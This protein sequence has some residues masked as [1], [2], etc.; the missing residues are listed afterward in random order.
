[1]LRLQFWMDP[2]ALSR[3]SLAKAAQARGSG[4]RRWGVIRGSIF[5]RHGQDLCESW[6]WL[7]RNLTKVMAL[8][9]LV[10]DRR[11]RARKGHCKSLA[12]CRACHSMQNRQEPLS[13]IQCPALAPCSGVCTMNADHQTIKLPLRVKPKLATNFAGLWLL[14]SFA[15]ASLRM[16]SLQSTSVIGDP[17]RR[18]KV[19]LASRPRRI[20]DRPVN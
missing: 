4:V 12:E 14:L 15:A 16:P 9:H 1:M 5:W 7:H 13:Q 3:F 20:L 10:V 19:R 8:N 2:P 6:S 18:L 17:G 11:C